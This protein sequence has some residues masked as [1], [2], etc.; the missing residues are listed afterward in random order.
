MKALP[1]KTL[2]ETFYLT[3]KERLDE[4]LYLTKRGG[5]WEPLTYR[6]ALDFLLR[7]LR[8]LE[9]CGFSAG[10]KAVIFAENREEWIVTDYAVQWMG[11]CVAAIYTTS[12]SEQIE[13]ILNESEAEIA[14][15]SSQAL[16]EKLLQ[17][18]N[19]KFLKTIV[20]WDA[21][22]TSMGGTP[23]VVLKRDF[24]REAMPEDE[25]LRILQR[26]RPDTLCILLYTSGTTGEPKG[27][28]LTHKN[29]L[30]NLRSFV[31]IIPLDAG[32]VTMSFLPLSHIYER[33]LHQYFVFCGI[34]IYFAESVDKLIE[35]LSEARPHLM[36][37]VP[38][39]FEKMYM[40]IVEKMRNAPA[41][42]KHLFFKAFWVGRKTISRRARGQKPYFPWNLLYWL[43]DFLVFKKVRKLT[44]GRVE[45][46]ISGGAPLS[47]EIN[48]FFFSAGFTILEGYGLSEACI[49][50]VNRPHAIRFGTV[51]VALPQVEFR[52]AEDGEI[53]ARGPMIMEG[54]YKKPEAT[55][56]AID[57]KGW[58]HT[59]DIGEIDSEGYL[60]ITDRK[61][62]LIVLA[63]GK[64]V[65]PQPIE[66]TLK[67]DPMI[68]NACL[69][70]DRRH[71]IS[72]L[73]VP[74]FDLC[75]TWGQSRGINLASLKDCVENAD[76]QAHFQK[77]IDDLNASL[78]RYSTIKEFRLLPAPFQIESGELTPTLKL[79]RRVI[80]EK[81]KTVIDAMYEKTPQ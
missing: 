41:L 73:I 53:L 4:V 40:R 80:N 31:E 45:I 75:K 29:L 37:C 70:G 18:K 19:F 76:L 5:R 74:N 69:I 65:P 61:K 13:Y 79:K 22:E 32:K 21:A 7:N 9:R 55:V 11:G 42:R 34:Q 15:V 72:A 56:E 10:K 14:F 47:Q 46:F 66:N 20:V 49:L 64:K 12:S 58:F 25:A 38:R 52:I 39:I 28:M 24:C 60:K 51:G 77:K 3:A 59:G 33:I 63:A 67:A 17:I 26:L 16:L 44:G 23:Q 2:P 57:S 54:Y 8:G 36:I 71:F 27:V 43:A 30:A 6:A 50:S 35:N 62:E 68:E 78:P 48:E 81:F 1:G